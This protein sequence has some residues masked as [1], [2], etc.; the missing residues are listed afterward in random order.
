[1]GALLATAN[2]SG[3]RE[4]LF[5]AAQPLVETAATITRAESTLRMFDSLLGTIVTSEE[6]AEQPD[7]HR[8][9]NRCVPDIEYQ[10]RPEVTEMQ[11][12]EVD[13]IAV[14]HA[15]ENVAER[16]AQHHPERR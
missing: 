11:V 7:H 10:K 13:D 14:P 2:S 1:S 5:N 9:A 8:N 16:A 15:V 4:W 3:V 6:R 12:G